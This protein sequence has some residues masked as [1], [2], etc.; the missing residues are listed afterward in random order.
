MIVSTLLAGC[1]T[2]PASRFYTLSPVQVAEPRPSV[3]PIAISIGPV[4]V[5]ELVDRPQIVSTIDANRVSIDEFAR[6]ADPLKRQIARTLAADLMQLMP[7]S[8]ASA[9]PQRASDNSYRVSVDVQRFDSPTS[10]DVTLA[11]I[12]SVRPPKGNA[13]EGHS[14]VREAVSGSGYDALIRAH[15]R[16]LASVAKDIAVAMQSASGQ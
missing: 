4:T 12:W 9:F 11:V 14:I 13:V 6:W 16:A 15:S 10:G 5:P 1:A 2:S 7:G 3:K 8:I